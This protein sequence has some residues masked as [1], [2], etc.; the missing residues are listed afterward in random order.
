MKKKKNNEFCARCRRGKY[1]FYE[2]AFDGRPRFRCTCCG[3]ILTFGK[4]GGHL[5]H[6][7][8]QKG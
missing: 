7:V 6:L 5:K 2:A 1:E 4:D 8:K 3:D